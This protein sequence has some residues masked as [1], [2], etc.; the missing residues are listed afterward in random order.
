MRGWFTCRLV[1]FG[2]ALSYAAMT[3]PTP[4]DGSSKLFQIGTKPLDPNDWLEPDAAMADQLAEKNRLLEVQR[5]AVFAVLKGSEAAQDELLTHLIDYLPTR[6]PHLWQREGEAMRILPADA[7][8]PLA[9]EEPSLLRAARLV[10][11]DLL[12]LE[13]SDEGWRLTAASLCFPSS[14]VLGEKIGKVLDQIHDPVPGFGPGTRAAQIIA[15]MFDATRPDM[16]MIRWNFSLYG[17]T[18][19]FHPDVSGPGERRFG[20][21]ERADPVYMRVE[22]QTL[23]KL[24]KTGA[25]AFTIRI[26]LDPIDRLETHPRGKEIAASLIEQVEALTP[27]QLDYKGL[28]LEKDRVVKRLMEIMR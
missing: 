13:R 3:F 14:W 24:P 27:E 25:I 20:T 12:L 8:V 6:F 2:S 22:R 4:Y 21:G 23:R 10:Q 18:R 16:P 17:D 1:K 9:G 11:D 15:R 26:S 28:T 7:L 19:L 5:D